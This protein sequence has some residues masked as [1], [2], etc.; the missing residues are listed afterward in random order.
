METTDEK[1]MQNGLRAANTV[2]EVL[3][4]TELEPREA[5]SARGIAYHVT[6]DGPTDQG[7][8]Q[9]LLD[10]E[11]FVFHFIFTG[12]VPVNRRLAVAELI[13]R[14]NWGLIE[15]NFEM[16]F[17]TGA[18]KYKVGIDF[19]GAE[20]TA[21]LVRNAVLSGMNNVEPF[22]EALQSVIDG[23]AEP[24]DAMKNVS[25]ADGNE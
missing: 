12:Y 5:R 18:L 8:A 21:E 23:T 25:F 3:E 6:F 14:A 24:K 4:R 7:I 19:T 1:A 9:I 15:G 13:T 10:A 17:D 20:L 2:R 22:A 16:S 11:R